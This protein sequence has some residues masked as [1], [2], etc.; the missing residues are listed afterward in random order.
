[1][2]VTLELTTEDQRDEAIS[3]SLRNLRVTELQ[4]KVSSTLL[5]I[6]YKKISFKVYHQGGIKN[7]LG[8]L[9]D[10]FLKCLYTTL[11]SQLGHS[12][13]LTSLGLL[14]QVLWWFR[15]IQSSI[16]H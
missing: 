2:K 16:Q 9:M 1:M 4:F 15:R 5:P 12:E 11:P 8:M 14:I 10:I 6:A 7:G 13:Q 3:S